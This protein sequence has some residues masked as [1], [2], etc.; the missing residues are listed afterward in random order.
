MATV[1]VGTQAIESAKFKADKVTTL[2]VI[3]QLTAT[4]ASVLTPRFVQ[5][6]SPPGPARYL[7]FQVFR[8]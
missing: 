3:A 1:R 6:V 7:L 4:S 5:N 2:V 8:T